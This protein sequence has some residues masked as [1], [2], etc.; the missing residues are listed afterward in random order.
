MSAAPFTPG[1]WEIKRRVH[2]DSWTV[3]TEDTQLELAEVY[4]ED[5]ETPFPVEANARLIA[6]AP[7]LYDALLL[8]VSS[9]SG[10]P[11]PLPAWG[12]KALLALRRAR[13][14]RP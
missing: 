13:G 9:L 14:E 10:Q 8:A 4:S 6:A 7:D 11:A 12:H 1:T 3:R 5:D 2:S